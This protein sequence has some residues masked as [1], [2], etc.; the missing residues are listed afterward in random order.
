MKTEK[1]LKEEIE[2][3]RNESEIGYTNEGLQ[4]KDRDLVVLK[5]KLKTL[6][7]RNAEVKQVLEEFDFEPVWFDNINHDK[8]RKKLMQKLGLEDEDKELEEVIKDAK[9]FHETS[10]KVDKLLG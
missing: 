6:Q 10:K 1:E 7:E 4:M 3:I 5:K 2:K 8:I 9:E